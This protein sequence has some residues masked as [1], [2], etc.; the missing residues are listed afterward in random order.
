LEP[1]RPPKGRSERRW[2]HLA[3]QSR[4]AAP[5]PSQLLAV[6]LLAVPLLVVPLLVVAQLVVALLVVALLVV[7]S[8][9]ESG[10]EFAPM[11]VATTAERPR[12]S[13]KQPSES[14]R[15]KPVPKPCQ[16]FAARTSADTL[17]RIQRWRT[18]KEVEEASTDLPSRR[19]RA[20]SATT[21]SRT[22]VFFARPIM[23]HGWL[24]QRGSNFTPISVPEV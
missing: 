12:K 10:R 7:A 9:P 21:L 5:D 23:L 22:C 11:R 15:L 1:V 2:A 18:L 13:R 3:T 17:T 6:A 24:T 4:Q 8:E 19:H 14:P 20:A 16:T